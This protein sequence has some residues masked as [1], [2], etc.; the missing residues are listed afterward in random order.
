MSVPNEEILAPG[1]GTPDF[2]PV[3]SLRQHR[4]ETT[5]ELLREIR[6]VLR[7]LNGNVEK[8]LSLASLVQRFRKKD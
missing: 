4:A 1:D 6:D 2:E 7:N 5:N 8:G 3:S